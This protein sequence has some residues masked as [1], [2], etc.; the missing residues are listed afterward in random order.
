MAYNSGYYPYYNNPYYNYVPQTPVPNQYQPQYQQNQQP[1]PQNQ[2]IYS[3][4]QWVRGEAAAKA[5][6]AEPGQTVLLMDSDEPVLYVNSTDINGKPAPMITYDLIERTQTVNRPVDSQDL[7][8][9][10]KKDEVNNIL[11]SI[12]LDNYITRSE[13][14]EYIRANVTNAIKEKIKDLRVTPQPSTALSI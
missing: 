8:E 10:A 4:F 12:N 6:R 9:Y 7:S 13:I 5:F 2:A 11:K 3:G 14:D 1:Q